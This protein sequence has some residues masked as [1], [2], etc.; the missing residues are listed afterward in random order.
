MVL[1]QVEEKALE[2]QI[3]AI[4]DRIRRG[5]LLSFQEAKTKQEPKGAPPKKSEH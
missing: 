4:R 2:A 1:S 3:A 5:E